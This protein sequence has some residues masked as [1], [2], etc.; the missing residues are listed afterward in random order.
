MARRRNKSPLVV[1]KDKTIGTT[2]WRACR[3]GCGNNQATVE[4]KLKLE[5][6]GTRIRYLCNGCGHRSMVTL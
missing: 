4:L 5:A 2:V 3:E 1:I 6:G